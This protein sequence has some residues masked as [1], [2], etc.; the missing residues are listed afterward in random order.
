MKMFDL[1]IF[2]HTRCVCICEYMCICVHSCVCAP[3]C[4]H[5]RISKHRSSCGEIAVNNSLALLKGE[6]N[7]RNG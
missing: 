2:T 1:L 7:R 5:L 6:R 4:A 3:G